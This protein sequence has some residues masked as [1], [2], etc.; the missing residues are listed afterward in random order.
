MVVDAVIGLVVFEPDPMLVFNPN[1][2]WGEA[3]D[4]EEAF[5]VEQIVGVL[6]QAQVGVPVAEVI[7]K[8]GSPNRP[9]TG[10]ARSMAGCR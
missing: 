8:L 7:R 6:K 1:L 3:L 9:T 2:T 4:E 5:S 10:G